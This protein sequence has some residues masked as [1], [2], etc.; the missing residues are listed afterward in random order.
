MVAIVTTEELSEPQEDVHFYL[1]RTAVTCPLRLPILAPAMFCL[2]GHLYSLLAESTCRTSFDIWGCWD[3]NVT[4]V[5]Y[6][7]ACQE[8]L[9][10]QG[11]VMQSD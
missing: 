10:T 2:W 6:F 4:H 3:N 9:V 8:F 5:C 7:S 11:S 1:E